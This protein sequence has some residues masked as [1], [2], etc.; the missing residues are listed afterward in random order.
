LTIDNAGANRDF[1]YCNQNLQKGIYAEE[2][3]LYQDLLELEKS[4]PETK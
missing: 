2:R 4:T 3:K 1:G